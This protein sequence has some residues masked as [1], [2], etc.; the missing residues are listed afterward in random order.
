MSI[1]TL[2]GIGEEEFRRS[3]EMRLRHGL[4]DAAVERLRGLL[5][6]YA[7]PD[8]ILPERFLTVT[9]NDLHIYG[10]EGLA[11][12]LRRHDQPWRPVTAL[13]I[14]FAWPGDDAPAPDAEGHLTPHIETGYYTDES[15]PFS[16]SARE[17][18]LEGYSFHGCTW[19]GDCVATDTGLSLGGVADLHGALAQLEARLLT[20]DEPDEDDIRAGSL[21]ACLLS[22]LL[23]QAVG[24]RIARDGLP[25]PLCVMAGSNGVYPYFDA[26]VVGMSEAASK[27]AEAA[28][29]LAAADPGIPGPRYSSLLLTSIP[30]AKKRAVLVLAEGTEEAA[31]RIADLRG[32]GSSDGEA[33]LPR[34]EAPVDVPEPQLPEPAMLPAPNGLLLAK[35]PSK[36]PW[37][38]RDMLEP[39]PPERPTGHVA[40]LEPRDPSPLPAPPIFRESSA[41]PGFVLLEPNPQ[42]RLQSLLERHMLQEVLEAEPAAPVPPVRSSWTDDEAGPAPPASL[43][44]AV[45]KNLWARLRAWLP[46]WRL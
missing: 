23:F 36:Q 41:E 15:F 33:R 2:D 14:A 1:V 4:A 31:T 27:A 3:I 30:R 16:Q 22:A 9:A 17:D 43:V 26:P 24:E 34:R 40:P 35:K 6:R 42:E 28:E 21:G 44:G 5:A 20:S 7:G 10:W 11:D 8:G 39:R 32:L 37:D 13:S 12:S 18:L 45:C 38:F 29:A 46:R 25:R 19:T